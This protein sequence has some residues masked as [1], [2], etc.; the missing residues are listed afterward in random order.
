MENEKIMMKMK[1]KICGMELYKDNDCI[2]MDKIFGDIYKDINGQFGLNNP[3]H[4]HR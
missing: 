3:K 2:E 4:W 1:C